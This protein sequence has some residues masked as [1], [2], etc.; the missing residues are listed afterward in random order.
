MGRGP[1]SRRARNH[2]RT[3]TKGGH[4]RKQ[5]Y[6]I[7]KLEKAH[8]AARAQT[9]AEGDTL[10]VHTNAAND[11]TVPR[12]FANTATM[13]LL[14]NAANVDAPRSVTATASLAATM[15]IQHTTST[16]LIHDMPDLVIP[17]TSKGS[18][19]KKIGGYHPPKPIRRQGRV[20]G[21]RGGLKRPP[22]APYK[23]GFYIKS[24]RMP[25]TRRL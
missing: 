14:T 16:T 21:G 20:Q 15:T 22:P 3:V 6:R 11:T 23:Y 18:P 2:K 5:K 13:P 17:G 9:P 10:V 25:Q 8:A 12:T 24:Y 7:K 1:R 4:I 19:S